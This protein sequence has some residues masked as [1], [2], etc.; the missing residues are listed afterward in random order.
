LSGKPHPGEQCHCQN[1]NAKKGGAVG[2]QRR[3]WPERFG[4]RAAGFAFVGSYREN[5]ARQD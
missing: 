5:W 1:H 2:D 4:P 3:I